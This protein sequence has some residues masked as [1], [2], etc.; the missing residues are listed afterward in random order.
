LFTL[1]ES[2]VSKI[3]FQSYEAPTL[4]IESVSRC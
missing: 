3:T 1:E 4:Q 2:D